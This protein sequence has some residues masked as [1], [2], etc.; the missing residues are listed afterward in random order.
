[1]VMKLLIDIVPTV[2]DLRNSP[3]DEYVS[4]AR[5]ESTRVVRD[6]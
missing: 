1:M 5:K 6:G 4:S 3:A 2:L